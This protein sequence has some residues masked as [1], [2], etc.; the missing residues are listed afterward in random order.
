MKK[1]EVTQALAYELEGTR[2]EY[3]NAIARLLNYAEAMGA[4][5]DSFGELAI[6][7]AKS[8]EVVARASKAPKKCK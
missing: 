4:Y 1:I 5:G 6:I 2:P 3:Q 8:G 7:S